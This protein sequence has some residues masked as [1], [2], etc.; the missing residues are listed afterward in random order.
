M[1]GVLGLRLVGAR[2]QLL[3]DAVLLLEA[4]AE[5]GLDLGKNPGVFYLRSCLPFRNF[6]VRAE[7]LGCQEQETWRGDGSQEAFLSWAG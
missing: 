5:C 2:E 6:L 1:T 3:V 4:G 7:V